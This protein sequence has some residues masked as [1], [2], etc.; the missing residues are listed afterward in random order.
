MSNVTALKSSR[1]T[2][3]KPARARSRP[4]PTGASLRQRIAAGAAVA[5]EVVLTGLSLSHQAVGVGIIV[6]SASE[7]ERWSMAAGIDCTYLVCRASMLCAPD[8]AS[9]KHVATWALPT[10][11]VA[12]SRPSCPTVI[13]LGIATPMPI[14]AGRTAEGRPRWRRCH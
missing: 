3:R 6:V 14:I 11:L 13:R 8:E 9:R 2:S 12:G 7:W 4:K 1:A 10:S 5:L